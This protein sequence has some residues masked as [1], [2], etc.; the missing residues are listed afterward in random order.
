LPDLR[1]RYSLALGLP[2]SA[3]LHRGGPG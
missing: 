1:A 3:R 2:A